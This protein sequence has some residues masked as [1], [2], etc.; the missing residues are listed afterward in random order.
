MNK[1]SNSFLPHHSS[2]PTPLLWRDILAYLKSQI[3]CSLEGT[4]IPWQVSVSINLTSKLEEE[5]RLHEPQAPSRKVLEWTYLERYPTAWAETGG[6]IETKMVSPHH[7]DIENWWDSFRGTT[8]HHEQ[9]G[10]RGHQTSP[11]K[12]LRTRRVWSFVS[13]PG[14]LCCYQLKSKALPPGTP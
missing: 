1:P 2:S 5:Y 13:L 3:S 8:I 9:R 11:S 6:I 12:A 14:I 7:C 10:Q 4:S